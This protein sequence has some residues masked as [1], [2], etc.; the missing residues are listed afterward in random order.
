MWF[1][2]DELEALICLEGIASSL[3]KGYL[4]EAFTSFKSRLSKLL[5]AQDI[6]LKEWQQRFKI[7]PVAYHKADPEIFRKVVD[8]TLHRQKLK[9]IYKKLTDT[10]PSER[11]LSPQA[12]VRYKDN[13]YVDAFCELSVGLRSFSLNRIREAIILQENAINISEELL[14]SF[15][16]QSYGIFIGSA[17]YT[18]E[19]LFTGIAAREVSEQVWHPQQCG[20][21][22]TDD[23]YMLKIPYGNSRELVMD[24]LR[25]GDGAEVANPPELRA[26]IAE[27]L[28]N[29]SKKYK[30]GS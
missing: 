26:E 22:L 10:D 20:Q 16:A 30:K 4:S 9:I 12:V 7:L 23:S 19:I 25:W 27:I 14:L 3:Q 15:F 6:E 29:T 24:I 8:A 21:W 11:V 2:T 5:I 13:W 1:K 17:V 28:D 18:A